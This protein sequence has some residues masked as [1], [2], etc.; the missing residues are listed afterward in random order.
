MSTDAVERWTKARTF[1]HSRYSAAGIAAA[2]DARGLS[3]SV[4]L[5]ARECARTVGEIVGALLELRE[6]GAIDEVVVVDAA[7][8]DG[9]ATV[10]ERAG[11]EVWQ[12]AELMP[13]LGPVLGKGDAMY[14]ALSVLGG[15][16]V[17]YLDADTSGFSAHY[18]IGLLGPLVCEDGQGGAGERVGGEGHP[19]EVGENDPG[20]GEG[21]E[22]VS[23][24]RE[25][26]EGVRGE[27]AGGEDDREIAFVKAYYRRP[28][29][30]GGVS[31]PEGGGRVN[32]LLA[33]PALGL[34][35]PELAG[36]VQPL[37]G[38]VAARRE[39]LERVPFVTGYGVEVGMLIDVWRE[40]GLEGIAQVDLE[41]H[42]N[43]H[44]SLGAL[45]PMARTVLAT[46][47]VRAGRE[48]R[49]AGVEIAEMVAERPPYAAVKAPSVR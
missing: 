20:K 22:G 26:R 34:F 44:Q 6:A 12:E 21:G 35:Y 39:L 40:V 46:I 18:A 5:P 4:C 16:I 10:A 3:V 8:A 36:V 23:G 25:G 45:E 11:A 2:R 49:L 1:H 43:S 47:A 48:G 9:T 24:E 32:R 28:F 27:R 14:R 29:E 7:S 13:E 19:E 17:C 31:L 42:R 37:A 38:E 30:H 15:E 33:R 41:E